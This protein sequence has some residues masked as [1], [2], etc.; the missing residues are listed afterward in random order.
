M[1]EKIFGKPPADMDDKMW[2]RHW[3]AGMGA[4][5]AVAAIS[6]AVFK[7]WFYAVGTSP[8]VIH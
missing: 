7:M 3:G 5:V 1:I 8:N 6:Y 4:I 2:M